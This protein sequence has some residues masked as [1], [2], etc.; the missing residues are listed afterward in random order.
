MVDGYTRLQAFCKVVLPQAT[1]GI[2]ATAIFCLIFC[3]ERICLRGAADQRRR[4]DHAAV[5]PLHH[6]R[7]RPGLAGG[8]RRDDAVPHPD[9]AASPI[10][11]R[12]HLLRGITFGAVRK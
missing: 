8:R 5:H 7:G 12:K 1:T 4:A 6:R 11:L 9:R 10:L 3:L 2:A